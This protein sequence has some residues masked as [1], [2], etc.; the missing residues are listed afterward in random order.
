MQKFNIIFFGMLM[1]Q[2]LIGQTIKLENYIPYARYCPGQET[3]LEFSARDIW[4]N[5]L[6]GEFIF[7]IFVNGVNNYD[8]RIEGAFSQSFPPLLTPS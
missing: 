2:L 5:K 8:I 3:Q 6:H 4:N 1:Y 7:T